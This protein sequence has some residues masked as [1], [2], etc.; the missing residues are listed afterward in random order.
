[1]RPSFK[2]KEIR[3]MKTPQRWLALLV[4]VLL[5]V[6]QVAPVAGEEILTND[7]VVTMKKAGLSDGVILARIR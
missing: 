1:M 5:G 3:V 4:V 2:E 6:L 7:S